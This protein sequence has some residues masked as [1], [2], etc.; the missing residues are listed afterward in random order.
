MNQAQYVRAHTI[1]KNDCKIR[2]RYVNKNGETCAIG[3]LAEAVDVKVT[4]GYRTRGNAQRIGDIQNARSL[5][6][7][8][9]LSVD[10][11]SDI[12]DVNDR[13]SSRKR[14]VKAVLAQLDHIARRYSLR[15]IG[16]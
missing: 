10:E 4:T 3:A 9:G 15:V 16:D 12:Q 2:Y 8:F 14:R 7:E 13:H 5:A 6:R 11:L 1:L